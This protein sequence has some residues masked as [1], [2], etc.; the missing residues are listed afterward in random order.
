MNSF[1]NVERALAYEIERQTR[2][3]SAGGRITQ[4]TLLWD[5]TRGEARAMRSKEESHDYRYFPDPDLPPLAI[6]ADDIARIAAALPELPAARETRLRTEYGL[7]RYDAEVLT[8]DAAVADYFEA[9]ARVVGDGK[10]ASNWV[11]T[12]LLGWL[13]QRGNSINECP[14]S[15]MALA[16]LIELVRRGAISH[17]A[18]R[19]VFQLMAESGRP[20]IELVQE[21]GLTQ[22]RDETQ[23][24]TWADETLRAFPDEVARYRAGEQKLLG[25]LMG[26]LMQRSGGKAD[27]KRASQLLRERLAE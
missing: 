8:A 2:V 6:S 3:L 27:P 14:V 25:F 10:L 26:Q 17:T 9:V 15:A 4:E 24:D 18:G 22:V 23:L 20:A 11:M 21:L 1:A 12:D 5:A 13:N 16:D 7:P 19:R